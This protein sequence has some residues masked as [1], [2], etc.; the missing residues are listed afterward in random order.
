MRKYI[1]AKD[2]LEIVT[3]E[4]GGSVTITYPTKEQ[5]DK[6]TAISV[7]PSLDNKNQ[8]EGSITGGEKIQTD[9]PK[10]E[11]LAKIEQI[12]S[13]YSASSNSTNGEAIIPQL[14]EKE[15]TMPTKE[16]IEKI[17]IEQIN[18]IYEAERQSLKNKNADLTNDLYNEAKEIERL[19][20]QTYS[21]IKRD[22][23]SARENASSEALKRGLARSSVI[24]NQLDGLTKAELLAI[25]DLNAKKN[26]SLNDVYEEIQTLTS[27]LSDALGS[28]D[29]KQA[30]ELANGIRELTEKYEKKQEEVLE[31]NNKIRQEQAKFNDKFNAEEGNVVVDSSS[32]D[33]IEMVSSKTKAFYSYYYSLGE[34]AKAEIEK[35]RDMIISEI[36][37]NGYNNLI[38]YFN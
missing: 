9:N 6:N 22:Y 5:Y 37:E 3:P 20:R 7:Y 8:A 24:L 18:P 30:S 19:A 36:G 28:L 32:K 21:G 17:V 12:N 11:L 35:D 2:F 27:R 26:Q 38:G 14:K 10:D 23:K 34:N 25:D 13:K 15:F 16:E 29:A 4:S 31:Y 33:Y 1:T